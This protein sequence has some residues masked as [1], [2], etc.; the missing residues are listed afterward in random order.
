MATLT[1]AAQ[2][3]FPDG[4][5]IPATELM[6]EALIFTAATQGGPVEGDAP[7]MHVPFVAADPQAGI[8]AEG[9]EIA[10]ADARLA[11]L[12]FRTTKVALISR[13]TNETA[14]YSR[15]LDMLVESSQRAVTNTVDSIFLNGS[16]EHEGIV[17]LLEGPELV[18]ATP[19]TDT[20]DP[21]LDVLG[22]IGDN[23][24]SPTELIMSYGTWGKLLKLKAGDGTPLISRTV[25]SAAEPS[26]FG[27]PVYVNSQMPANTILVNDANEVYASAG[28]ATVATSNSYFFGSDSLALRVTMRVGWGVIHGNRLGKVT[29]AA[30]TTGNGK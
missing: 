23:G 4:T 15:T 19:I 25:A 17:G 3:F 13:V 21:M 27:L 30:K 29:L 24:G 12:S 1:S 14:T 28:Q 22:G 7:F 26:L 5:L 6:P 11:Q 2:G 8:V 10:P 20:L 9:D 16:P 18:T